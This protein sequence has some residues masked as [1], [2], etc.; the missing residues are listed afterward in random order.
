[1]ELNV[2]RVHDGLKPLS[3]ADIEILEGF[4]IG[5]GLS[6][7]VKKVNDRSLQ[8]L[9]LYW[10]GLVELVA[11]HWGGSQGLIPKSDKSL[12]MGLVEF[13]AAQGHDTIAISTLINAYLSD[14]AERIRDRIPEFEKAVTMRDK[15]HQWLKEEAGYCD[16][17]LTPTGI[18]K[19]VKSINFNTMKTQEEFNVFYKKVFSVA[20]RYVFS[21]ANF[22]DEREAEDMAM[23]LSR[24][25]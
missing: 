21:R 1:M 6:V 25:G 14:R 19:R 10:G 7:K 9:R 8:H 20:W 3:Q 22:K 16:I 15:V 24:M 23:R 12:M 13:V 18:T 11:Q 4:K 2:V 5:Q 17:V